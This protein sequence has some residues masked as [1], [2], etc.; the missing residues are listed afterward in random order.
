ML[1][2]KKSPLNDQAKLKVLCD[3]LCD[4]IEDL[5]EHF[6]L[7]Y[8]DHGKMISMACPIHEGDNESALNL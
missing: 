3:D 6:E 1:M 2:T 7:D 8:K 4:N 5:L